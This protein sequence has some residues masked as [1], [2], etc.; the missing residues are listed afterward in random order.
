MVS[1]S[2]AGTVSP[3]HMLSIVGGV[4]FTCAIS[5]PRL[6]DFSNGTLPQVISYIMTPSE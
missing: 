3:G 5:V 2:S 1:A 6:F 4:S